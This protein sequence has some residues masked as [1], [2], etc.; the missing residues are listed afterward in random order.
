MTVTEPDDLPAD[1]GVDEAAEVLAAGEPP[2]CPHPPG[3]RRLEDGQQVCL[4]CGEAVEAWEQQPIVPR[5][6]PGGE[7]PTMRPGSAGSNGLRHVT[8]PQDG[9]V[10]RPYTPDEL[11]REIVVVLD[12]IERGAGWL[13][14]EEE[15]RAAAKLAYEVNFAKARFRSD[16][17]SAEQ[18]NDDAM[19]QCLNLY[20]EWQMRE[21]TCRTAREGLHNLRSMLS[22]LQSVLRSIGTALGGGGGYR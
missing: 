1:Y 5:E 3:D 20:E 22:G 9:Q 7:N 4:A 19:L 8:V 21:L 6:R 18:R 14:T 13:T 16:G 10:G 15:K 12:R 17:R 11:E 2:G